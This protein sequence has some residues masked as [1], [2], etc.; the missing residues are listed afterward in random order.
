MTEMEVGSAT[1]DRIM[2]LL[3]EAEAVT[4]GKTQTAAGVRNGEEYLDLRNL[5]HGVLRTTCSA[6]DAGH[7]LP[8]NAVREATWSRMLSIV[9]RVYPRLMR[10]GSVR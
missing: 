6:R 9:D 10:P 5:E 1:R 8:R 4:V 2:E 3:S 7:V